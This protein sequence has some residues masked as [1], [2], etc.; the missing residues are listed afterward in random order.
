MSYSPRRMDI[1]NSGSLFSIL[2]LELVFLQGTLITRTQASSGGCFTS[3][4]GM[5]KRRIPD[6]DITASSA[7][8]ADS[9]AFHARVKNTKAWIPSSNDKDPWIQVN[10]QYGRNMTAIVTQG[11]NGSFVK[12]YYVS[13]GDDGSNWIN[14]TVQ[15]KL[16]IW[17][18]NVGDSHFKTEVF[19]PSGIQI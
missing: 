16:K 18:G 2:I 8:D 1:S 4:F 12:S 14:Y 11:F 5:A 7:L 19:S 13:Y 10:L 15:G 6:R 3:A 17:K 9:S